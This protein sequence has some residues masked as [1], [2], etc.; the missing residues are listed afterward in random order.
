MELLPICAWADTSM[1]LT[2]CGKKGST[3]TLQRIMHGDSRLLHGW[4]GCGMP[5][6][7]MIPACHVCLAM[8]LDVSEV[9]DVWASGP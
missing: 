1:P 2:F 3:R 4:G 5:C 7:C 6:Y 8:V 9:W